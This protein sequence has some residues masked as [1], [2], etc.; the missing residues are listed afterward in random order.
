VKSLADCVQQQL[1]AMQSDRFEVGLFRPLPAG[2]AGK[3]AAMMLRTWDADTVIRSLPWLRFE[4]RNERNI[5]V[6]PAGEHQMSLVDDLSASSI[7]RMLATGF[8]PAAVIETSSGNFQAWMNHGRVLSHEV[9]T[10]TARALAQEFQGDAKAADWRHFGRLAGF[11][12]RKEKHRQSSGLFP[13]V[14]LVEAEGKVYSKAETFVAVMQERFEEDRK[15]RTERM[16]AS[17]VSQRF[18]SPRKSIEVFRRSAAYDGDGTRSDL[19]YTIYAIS[20]GVSKPEIRAALR[21]RDLSHKGG[22][23]RQ[24]AYIERTIRK[25]LDLRGHSR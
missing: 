2:E 6:R 25:A 4:N 22:E 24:E 1:I 7:G 20:R 16:T 10:L 9:S 11:T 23:R 5:Y 17:S 19:A 21:S 8:E 12:N 13:Y 18:Q 14:R 15:L 3:Q